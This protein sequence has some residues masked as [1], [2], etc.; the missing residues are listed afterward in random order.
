M[1]LL[2]YSSKLMVDEHEQLGMLDPRED[3]TIRA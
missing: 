2:Q 1:P 3:V